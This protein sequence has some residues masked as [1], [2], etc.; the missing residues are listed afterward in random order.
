[1]EIFHLLLL[2]QLL[3]NSANFQTVIFIGI[4]FK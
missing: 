2:Y 3:Y 1:M 4:N